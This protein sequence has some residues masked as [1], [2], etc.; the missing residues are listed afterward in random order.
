MIEEIVLGIVGLSLSFSGGKDVSKEEII[1]I[2]SGSV[3]VA[4]VLILIG[5]FGSDQWVALRHFIEIMFL[6]YLP[7][8]VLSW[9]RLSEWE[10]P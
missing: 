2:V 6:S 4:V 9:I 10:E 5:Y 3:F 8:R 7:M 1:G